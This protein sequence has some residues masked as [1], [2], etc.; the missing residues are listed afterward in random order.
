[1]SFFK[2]NIGL[3]IV[4][5]LS[6]WVIGPFFTSGFFPMHDDTQVVRVYQMQQALRD[7]Q[8]P[9]RWVRDLGYGYGYPLFNF[10]APLPYYIGGLVNLSGVNTLDSTKAMMVIGILFAGIFM[11]FLA[12]EFWGELGGVLS[13]LF[14]VYAPYHAV[15]IYVR[16]AVGEFWA[17]GFIPLLFYGLWKLSHQQKWKWV[18]VG[19]VGLAGIILSHN[20]TAMMVTPFI[21]IAILLYCYIASKEREV[22]YIKYYILS[23]ILGLALSAFYWIPAIL[24]IPYTNIL[25]QVGGGADFRDHFVCWQQL[26]ESNWGFG[27]SIPGCIDGLSFKI[28]KLHIITSLISL[29]I[30]VYSW[31][32]NRLQSK[33]ILVASGCLLVASLMTLEIS[34][35]VWQAISP[36][37][38]I[39]YPWRFLVIVAF[40][41]SFLTGAVVWFVRNFNL[42]KYLTAG[43]L[44]ILL[45]SFNIKLFQPQMIIARTADFY[46]D[47]ENIKWTI[48]KTS[49]EYMPKDF[50]KPTSPNEIARRRVVADNIK[51]DKTNQLL[52]VTNNAKEKDIFVNIAPFP[53]WKVFIDGVSSNYVSKDSGIEIM[54]PAGRH[55]VRLS[56]LSTFIEELANV[57]S[58]SSLVLFIA[59]IIYSRKNA[60]EKGS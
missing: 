43:A 48:S 17:Y 21:I 42:L 49:D 12:R 2:K 34:K 31:K 53:A 27:G 55:E 1:M 32:K 40:T 4:I 26:W 51:I 16:G 19:A 11:Y 25:S 5:L 47:E 28:G 52:F 33:I 8:I 41:T 58:V 36:L 14:Y 59:I 15:D 38:F 30:G 20:L 60:Y 44:I 57:I 23:I 54:V 29:V 39:Q 22:L 10:Y 3:F 56:F 9:V 35:P 6:L 13:G 7:G 37:A 24:E 45:L 46:T 18:I 50:K